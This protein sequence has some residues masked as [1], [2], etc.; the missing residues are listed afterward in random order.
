MNTTSTAAPLVVNI[1]TA[2]LELFDLGLAVIPVN[3]KEALITWAQ[4][5]R[6]RPTR[7]TVQRWFK[8]Q[9]IGGRPI[10]GVAVI[11]GAVSG[12]VRVRDFDD[13]RGYLAWANAYPHLAA[14]LPTS[15]TRRGFHVF[16]AGD[17]PELIK[18]MGDGEYRG[19]GY[20]VA[21]TSLHPDGGNYSWDQPPDP[22]GWPK[23][24][25]FDLASLAPGPD[26][27][28][29]S[30]SLVES[31]AVALAESP[32]EQAVR[33]T[34]PTGPGQ[35]HRCIWALVGRLKGIPG[36]WS[37]PERIS[38]IR[39]WHRHALPTIRTKGFGETLAD[40]LTAWRN[41]K[42]AAGGVWELTVQRALAGPCAAVADALGIHDGSLRRLMTLMANLQAQVGTFSLSCR[43]AGEAIGIKK[44]QAH[45]LLQSLEGLGVVEVV[46]QGKPGKA[47]DPATVWRWIGG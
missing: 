20:V 27:C 13:V 15:R 9:A 26:T 32:V 33:L 11:L 4:C 47:G 36:K 46:T 22:A 18:A 35:R 41:R 29:E 14:T 17:G 24:T 38:A 23:L 2:A 1:A 12:G 25:G 3:G 40:Y 42:Y 16:F 44:T 19:R 45:Q 6:S 28:N 7:A 10:T 31:S 21:P 39:E 37:P 34:L 5:Q 30:L 8:L 43:Q